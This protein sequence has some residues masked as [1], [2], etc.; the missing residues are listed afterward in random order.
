[1]VASSLSGDE[2]EKL[3]ESGDAWDGT[4]RSAMTTR[5]PQNAARVP[6]PHLHC[7][8]KQEVSLP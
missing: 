2:I 8:D 5:D 4:P 7:E 3:R 6:M 1:V